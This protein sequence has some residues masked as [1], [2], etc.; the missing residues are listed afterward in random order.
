MDQNLGKP[1][2]NLYLVT[3]EKPMKSNFLVSFLFLPACFSCGLYASDGKSEP[4]IKGQVLDAVTKKPVPGVV[5]SAMIPGDPTSQEVLTD[6]DGYYY[7]KQLPSCQCKPP[8]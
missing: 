7:F 3:C 8:L 2:M 4:C 6:V 5:V 1:G